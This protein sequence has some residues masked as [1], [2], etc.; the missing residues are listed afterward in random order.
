[1]Q[2]TPPAYYRPYRDDDEDED[3]DDANSATSATTGTT[4]DDEEDPRY[5]I[6]KAAGPS[7]NTLSSQMDYERGSAAAGASYEP[8]PASTF[9]NSV[10]YLNP[11]RKTQTSLFSIKSTNRDQ[12]VYPTASHFSLKLPRVYKN[13]S[14]VQCVQ[15]SFPFYQNAVANP[16][17]LQ[18]TLL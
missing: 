18:S 10:L 9:S 14:Q 15:I 3:D 8:A 5:A 13:V 7:F 11:T 17:T 2:Y 12:S 1:M 16:S 4:T 6:V